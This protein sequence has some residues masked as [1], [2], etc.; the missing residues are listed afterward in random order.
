MHTT[1]G[2]A[3]TIA[4]ALAIADS[5]AGQPVDQVELVCDGEVNEFPDITTLTGVYLELLPA[6]VRVVGAA[7]FEGPYSVVRR[8]EQVVSFGDDFRYGYVNRFDG[9]LTM[10]EYR[11]SSKVGPQGGIRRIYTARRRAVQL[12]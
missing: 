10:M 8:T 5:D 4:A 11:E 2:A 1:L 9:S 7:W 3:L 12:F 6:R